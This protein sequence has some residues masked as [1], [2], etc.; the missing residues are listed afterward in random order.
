[1]C[2]PQANEKTTKEVQEIHRVLKPKGRFFLMSCELNFGFIFLKIS[3]VL[4]LFSLKQ[5]KDNQRDEEIKTACEW[6]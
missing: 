4:I 2:G 1:M 5:M 6:V 3:V